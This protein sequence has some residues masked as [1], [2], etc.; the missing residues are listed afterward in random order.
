MADLDTSKHSLNLSESKQRYSIPKTKRFLESNKA[1]YTPFYSAVTPSITYQALPP[2]E[3][4]PSVMATRPWDCRTPSLSLELEPTPSIVKSTPKKTSRNLSP[5]ESADRSFSPNS[6]HVAPR[7]PRTSQ[8]PEVN[9]SPRELQ[10]QRCSWQK[11]HNSQ[12]KVTRS[13][14][15]QNGQSTSL[16]IKNPGPGTYESE[17]MGT[18]RYYLNSLHKNDTNVKISQVSRLEPI[19]NKLKPKVGPSDYNPVDS[20][21]STGK[22]SLAQH[23]GLK[24]CVFSRS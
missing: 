3:E 24:S 10:S 18:N 9:P 16:F 1:L 22:Y 5:S 4:P 11:G 21:S 6:E 20:M 13:R 19:G 12:I 7:S 15:R 23:Q 2:K 14:F 8:I 17:A